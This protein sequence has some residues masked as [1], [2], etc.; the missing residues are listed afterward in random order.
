MPPTHG[1]PTPSSS[2]AGEASTS[3]SVLTPV[4]PV[5]PASVPVANPVSLAEVTP[6][7]TV[8]PTTMV[9]PDQQKTY[10]HMHDPLLI[11]EIVPNEE[12]R[13]ESRDEAE[14]F[15]K[16]YASKAGFDVRITKT[17]K[18]VLEMSCNKQGHWDY[19]KPDEER[20]R[21][22]MSMRCDV[23]L[24][25]TVNVLSDIYGGRQNFTFTERDLKNRKAAVAKAERENDIPKLLEFFKEMKAHN[26]YFYYD[27]QDEQADTFEWLFQAFQDCM[28]GSRD[29][30]CILTD[31]DSAMAAAIKRGV[32][33]GCLQKY[34]D[35]YIYS[36][37][38]RIDSD[39]DKADSFLV[40]H[41]NHSWKYSWFQHSF[42]VEANVEEGRYTCDCKTWEHT[43]CE[44]ERYATRKLV[45]LVMMAV[46]AL[47]K[48]SIGVERGSKD[49]QAL[50]EWGESVAVGTGPSQMGDLRN[51]ENVSDGIRGPEV[52]AV[53]EVVA[54]DTE[55]DPHSPA[56][57]K[58]KLI[59]ECA[60]KGASTKGRKRKGKQIV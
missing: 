38:F 24:N 15:Y 28:L 39:A 40:T 21:E 32:H 45:D 14:E 19:Y 48:T 1:S 43:D 5:A 31:Q 57:R 10:M 60:P 44:D 35:T 27:L 3:S 54:N 22:K 58:D 6:L 4:Q 9:T 41:T 16:F 8:S 18:M 55:E 51:E 30:R 46:R 11:E 37:A 36:T 23:P 2:A 17:M 25:A 34:R 50:A 7:R 53:D 52:P 13:F 49:L 26:E 47:H 12:L 29:P 20:I 42:K 33:M 56:I 59:S